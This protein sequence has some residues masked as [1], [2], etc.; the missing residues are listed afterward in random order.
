[1][2]WNHQLV[3]DDITEIQKFQKRGAF[4]FHLERSRTQGLW[5]PFT[6]TTGSM[7]AAGKTL[8]GQVLWLDASQ[9]ALL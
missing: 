4:W 7:V 9:H 2:G 1:M 3:K 6:H 5:A 8:M